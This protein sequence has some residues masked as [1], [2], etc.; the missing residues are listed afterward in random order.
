MS[1]EAE[2]GAGNV[3]YCIVIVYGLLYMT[4]LTI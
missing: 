2:I 1:G 3:F 4:A